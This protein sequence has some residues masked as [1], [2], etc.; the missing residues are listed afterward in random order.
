MIVCSPGAGGAA[1]A[2][3]LGPRLHPR[4]AEGKVGEPRNDDSESVRW[5]NR[6]HFDIRVGDERRAEVVDQLIAR[7]ATKLWDGQ[8][9]PYSWVTMSD[10]EGNEFCVA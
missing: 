1:S 8:Q 2:L 9:G 6:L 4:F 7:G 10:P 3:R 5:H